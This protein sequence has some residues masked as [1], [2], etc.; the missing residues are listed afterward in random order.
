ME[1]GRQVGSEPV[2]AYLTHPLNPFTSLAP[3]RERWRSAKTGSL[4]RMWSGARPNLDWTWELP[5]NA[6]RRQPWRRM[7]HSGL[8]A[9]NQRGETGP[10]A[11]AGAA[12][13]PRRG[14]KQ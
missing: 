11:S 8:A 13:A 3:S 4:K 1:G 14:M 7:E 9:R 2:G 5:R 6:R 10:V 12:G